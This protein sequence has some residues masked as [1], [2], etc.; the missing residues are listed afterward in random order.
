MF[1]YSSHQEW[2]Q[3]LNETYIY[4]RVIEDIYLSKREQKIFI[5]FIRYIKYYSLIFIA[6]KQ[7]QEHEKNESKMELYRSRVLLR[8][9]GTL[10]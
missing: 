5:F 4:E 3:N 8:V 1:E 10:L 7:V 9:W 6:R 2:N